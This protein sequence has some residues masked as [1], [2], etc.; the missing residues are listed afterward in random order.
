MD[1]F[2][3]S[4]TL[5][6]LNCEEIESLNRP[7]TNIEIESLIKNL[8][9]KKSPGPDGFPGEF[10]Q[11]FKEELMP[12]LLNSSKKL[13]R[14]EHFQNHFMRPALSWYKVSLPVDFDRQVYHKKTKLQ[15]NIPDEYW[16]KNPQ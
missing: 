13:K 5:P 7:K 1:K 6:R 8:T 10:Y 4:Y 2:L 15:A 14:R 3:E 12:I 16:C 9:T 11:I